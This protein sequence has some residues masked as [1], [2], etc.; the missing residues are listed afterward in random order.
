MYFHLFLL[1]FS[2]GASSNFLP[3]KPHLQNKTK[4][5]IIHEMLC[6]L[7]AEN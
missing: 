5:T 3:L 4:N 1:L 2:S 7:E 6:L